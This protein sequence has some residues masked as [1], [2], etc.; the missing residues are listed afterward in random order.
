MKK[1][2]LGCLCL[3]LGSCF[4]N[5]QESRAAITLHDGW[6][7]QSSAKVDQP[8]EEIS[9]PKY[10]PRDWYA[11]SVPTTVAAALVKAK[12]YPDPMFGM[13]LRSLPGV[14][15]P[16]G[17]NF[18]NFPMQPDSPF[19]VPWWYRKQFTL[20]ADIAGKTVWLKFKGLNYR[21]NIWLNGKLLAKEEDV[22]GAWRTYEFD[23]TAAAQPGKSNVLAVEVWAPTETDLAITFVDWN[24]APPDRN[25]GLW[26]DVE[27][28]TSG[29]VAV[30]YPTVVSKVD[31]PANDQAHLT[32]SA[33]V[34]NAANHSVKGTLQGRIE[35]IE[36]SQEV[37]LAPG[38]S[39][40]VTFDPA[41]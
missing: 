8:G 38:E 28:T 26:R 14:S 18:S 35:K 6:A 5:A 10:Q 36:F 27:I 25:M 12:V 24:P 21:A 15:Y 4:L 13:N 29:P 20:P 33:L 40:D 23:I 31:S 37:E 16:I 22:A 2:G 1:I 7:L 19:A 9:T 34:K 39:K 17:G 32:V 11:V 41:K 3:L 30:R